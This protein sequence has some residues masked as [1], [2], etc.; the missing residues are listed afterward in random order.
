MI[1]SFIIFTF[2]KYYQGEHTRQVKWTGC[3]TYMGE[4]RNAYKIYFEDLNEKDRLTDLVA[5]G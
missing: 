5:D 4:M 1:R 2:T 3:V